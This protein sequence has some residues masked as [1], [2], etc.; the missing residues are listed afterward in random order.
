MANTYELIE[1]KTLSSPAASVTFTSIPGTYT[2]LLLSTSIR[3]S[4]G[5]T[6]SAGLRFNGSTTNYSER[7]LYGTGSSAASANA[8]TTSIQWANLGNDTNTSNTFSNCQIYIPNYAGSTNKSVSTESVTENNATGA[9]IY[10]DAGLWSD[11][12]AITSLTLTASTPDFAT[13]STFYLYGIK[14]S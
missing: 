14:N 2:D 8:T 3:A 4:S 11:T 1:A 10:L 5:G 12:A 9:D 7:L 6:I 13:N